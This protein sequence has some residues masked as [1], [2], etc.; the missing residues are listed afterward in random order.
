MGSLL[1]TVLLLC[2]CCL[3][4]TQ[5]TRKLKAITMYTYL[6]KTESQFVTVGKEEVEKFMANA[7]KFNGPPD[8]KTLQLGIPS[9]MVFNA[10]LAMAKEKWAT[11]GQSGEAH[12]Q[13]L[14][15]FCKEFQQLSNMRVELALICPHVMIAKPFDKRNR[16]VEIGLREPALSL[17]QKHFHPLIQQEP[18]YQTL[19]GT[20]RETIARVFRSALGRGVNDTLSLS[21][22]ASHRARSAPG[23]VVSR[24]NDHI[25]QAMTMMA[26]GRL[27][28]LC[29]EHGL[30]VSGS[31]QVLIDRLRSSLPHLRQR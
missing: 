30:P 23:P 29:R 11:L 20:A 3:S 5:E 8:Q 6:I 24:G 17:Y 1:E 16:R 26:R 27:V 2:K 4:N 21:G 28:S 13:A 31:K 7:S 10:W 19:V 25:Q 18:G 12:V 22:N 14:D 9:I 15:Q